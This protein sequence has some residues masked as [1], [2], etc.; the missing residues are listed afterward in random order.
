MT[1]LMYVSMSGHV[2]AVR[3]LFEKGANLE[4]VEKVLIYSDTTTHARSQSRIH[5]HAHTHT[6]WSANTYSSQVSCT[7]WSSLM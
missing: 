6:H 7:I 2:G 3:V 1:S 5:T 4:S